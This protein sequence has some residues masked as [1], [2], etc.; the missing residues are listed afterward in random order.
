MVLLVNGFSIKTLKENK[1]ISNNLSFALEQGDKLALI[2]QEGIGKSTFLKALYDKKLVE[3]YAEVKGTSNISDFSVSYFAQSLDEKY[4]NIDAMTY[5]LCDDSLEIDPTKYSELDDVY[6][7]FNKL[8]LAT[9]LLAANEPMSNLSGG[10]RIKVELVKVLF[11][12]PNL[13]LLDE[14][15]NDLDLNSIGTIKDV[16]NSFKG[17]V[18]FISHDLDFL[19]STA[20]SIVHFEQDQKTKDNI[21]T[22]ANLKYKDYIFERTKRLDKQDKLHSQESKKLKKQIEDV[23]SRKE[24]ERVYL[25]T[26]HKAPM[27]A[28]TKQGNMRRIISLEGRLESKTITPKSNREE[29][30]S[31]K[32]FKGTSLD[33]NQIITELKDF[34]L[35][36]PDKKRILLKGLN[37]LIRGKDR[38]ALIGDNGIGKTTLLNSIFLSL[39][40]DERLKIGY[41]TQDYNLL[42]DND[43]TPIEYLLK[44]IKDIDK[45]IRDRYLTYLG[46]FK[47]SYEEMNQNCR[48]L[49]GGEKAKLILIKLSNSDYNILLLDEPTR[50]LSPLTI[51]ILIDSMK[52]YDGAIIV[53]SHDRFFIDQMGLDIIDLNKFKAEKR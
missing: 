35:Y 20:T 4:K 8:G 18:I 15:T 40:E 49:S 38:I 24:T 52:K 41:M 14:P 47:F 5:I 42:V 1:T 13:L 9:D 34:D 2:G 46:S 17:I 23:E 27:H 6:L 26:H 28:L 21:V 7:L 48:D 30:I 50:N 22:F 32:E 19:E 31:V 25:N 44:D 10:E 3:T 16:I 33:K 53:V 37:L 45:E 11:K 12:K 29:A 36:T 39:K 51:P 43:L